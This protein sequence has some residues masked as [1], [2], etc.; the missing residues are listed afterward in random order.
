MQEDLERLKLLD[1]R[2]LAR[3]LGIHP[4]TV[5]KWRRQEKLPE[6]L[7]KDGRRC[8]WAVPQIETWQRQL[9]ERESQPV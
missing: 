8:F 6:P 1:Q 7:V 3:L 2:A 9:R 5:A 4:D